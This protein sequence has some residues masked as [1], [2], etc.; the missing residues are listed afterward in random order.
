MPYRRWPPLT[1]GVFR[2][3]SFLIAISKRRK[4]KQSRRERTPSKSGMA[5]SKLSTE[6]QVESIWLLGGLSIKQLGKRVW[7]EMN[8]DSVTNRAYELAYN[9]LFALF[10]LL[11]F[12]LAMLGIFAAQAPALKEELISAFAR[13]LPGSAYTLLSTTLDEVVKASGGGKIT[14]GIVLGLWSATGG[15]T[16]MMSLQ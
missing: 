5:E 8:H 2:S 11:L 14:L 3:V 16:T 12:L 15:T 9:F 6:K 7:E 10:P 13:V 1:L 4:C